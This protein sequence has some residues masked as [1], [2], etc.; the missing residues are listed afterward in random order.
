MTLPHIFG[1]PFAG[2]LEW[3][4]RASL[5]ASFI[6]ALVLLAQLF[7]GR[8]LTPAWRYRLWAVMVARLILPVL[9]ASPASLSNFDLAGHFRRELAAFRDDHIG[10]PRPGESAT[11]SIAMADAQ[12]PKVTVIYG[13][14]P[15]VIRPRV[16]QANPSA[17]PAHQPRVPLPAIL[18]VVWSVGVAAFLARLLGANFRLARRLRHAAGATDAALLD[19]FRECCRR[20]RVRRPPEL[21][22]T[23]AVRIPATAGL[24]RPRI[25][26]PPGLFDGLSDQQQRSVLFHELAH[27]KCRD[28]LSNWVLAMAQIIHWFN[29]AI[30]WAIGRLKLD[31]EMARDAMALRWI[32]GDDA[33]VGREQYAR[34]LLNL[35][36]S[37][38]AGPRCLGMA[39][40]LAGICTPAARFISGGFGRGSA[41]KRRLQMIR[42]SGHKV[43]RSTILGTLLAVALI[44]CT[45]TRAQDP[46]AP[47]PAPAPA[48]NPPAPTVEERQVGPSD[49]DDMLVG[50]ARDLIAQ[51]KYDEA[52]TIL[53]EIRAENPKSK[54]VAEVEPTLLKQIEVQEKL[55]K[56]TKDDVQKRLDRVL[57]EVTFDGVGLSDVI[58]FMRDVSGAKIFVNWKSLEAAKID[59]NAPVTVRLRNVQLFKALNIILDA[60]AGGG[61]EKL[62][63]TI[64]DGVLTI[65][66]A[67]DLGKNV[68]VRVYDV[69][70]LLVIPPD[71]IP[72]QL[73]GGLSGPTTRPTTA[74]AGP[75]REEL[76]KSLQAMIEDTVAPET[77]KDHG[78]NV[79]AL[80]ELQG[81]L[82][83]TQTPEN[84]IEIMRILD[85]LRESRNLQCEVDA[86][87]ISCEEP[88]A[89]ALLIKWQ[90]ALPPAKLSPRSGSDVPG[91]FGPEAVGFFLDDA[92]VKELLTAGKDATRFSVIAAPRIRL[93]NGQRADVLVATSRRYISDYAATTVAGGQMRY[94]PVLSVVQTGLMLDVQATANAD[95]TAATLS[96]RPQV[97]ALIGMKQVPWPGRPVDLMV[98]EPQVR[99]TELQTTVSIPDGRTLLL[100]GLEDP[101]VPGDSAAATRPDRPLRSLFL[102]VKPKLIAAAVGEQKQFPLLTPRPMET[103]H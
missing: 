26:L 2:C 54:F 67:D 92:Q 76:V 60:A 97:S 87:F 35:T 22:M 74:P 91:G 69:R 101:R 89:H 93:F 86:Q 83:I 37:L 32:A 8:W 103:K 73:A 30:A 16:L 4:L 34:T 1:G 65:S 62:G 38:S 58:D 27:V 82:I 66:T 64:D 21:L 39:A 68:Q 99:S 11:A 36:E 50:E 100:G 33:T 24:G 40:G 31:R 6:A 78:G 96:L 52:L 57:P 7:F 25:L 47:R 44:S 72:S 10:D 88:V 28:V 12:Q 42:T 14:P 81:Q 13:A 53:K 75:T 70:D 46:P 84:Q 51:H 98:Q 29:P 23:D 94:D 17:A 80:R 56:V 63:Y 20:A 59:R 18:F 9:P 49:K 3:L 48:T 90:K 19:R 79:A 85:Q 102:L 15:A 43:A 41:L 71:Y 55:A 61:R 95:R 45:L 77:W 5:S